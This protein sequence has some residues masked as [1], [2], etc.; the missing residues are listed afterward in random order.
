[1][2]NPVRLD[3]AFTPQAEVAIELYTFDKFTSEVSF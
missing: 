1:M 2:A 3:Q